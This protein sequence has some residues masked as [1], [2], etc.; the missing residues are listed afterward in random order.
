M[1]KDQYKDITGVRERV[2]HEILAILSQ[3][4]FENPTMRFGQALINLDILP[5]NKTLVA[6]S[7]LKTVIYSEEPAVILARMERG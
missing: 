6:S 4:L 1:N 5:N 3:Y 2:N 7:D